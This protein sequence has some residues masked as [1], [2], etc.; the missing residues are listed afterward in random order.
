MFTIEMMRGGWFAPTVN[1]DCVDPRCGEL[2]YITGE[3]RA[4]DVEFAMN[5]NFAFGGV[6]TS[7]VFRRWPG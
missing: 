1:L 3:G 4:L 6:N 5:N 2:D 7:L